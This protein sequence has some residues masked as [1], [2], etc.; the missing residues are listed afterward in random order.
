MQ[1]QQLPATPP[2]ANGDQYDFIRQ[3]GRQPTGTGNNNVSFVGRI[4]IVAGGAVVL[5]VL[6][7]VFV[8]LLAGPKDPTI[9]LLTSIAQQQNEL[10]RVS[11]EPTSDAATQP[12]LNFANT[13]ALSLQSDQQSL[14]SLLATAGKTPD[15]A[16]LG[17]TQH[18]ATDATLTAAKA[19]GTYDSVFIGI[20]QAQLTAYQQSLQQAFKAA[21]S[22][23]EKQWLTA[24]YNHAQLLQQ[25]S[26]QT[27]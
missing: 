13:T 21:Q 24:A 6:A 8:K 3:Y 26:K 7:I 14:I 20:A 23:K 9:P 22:N 16:T 17:A 19:N 5:I 25:M 12:T 4:L 10:A 11:A 15:A 2:P 18:T 1:P 27:E